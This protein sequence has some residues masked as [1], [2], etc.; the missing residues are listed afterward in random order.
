M[1]IQVTA[2]CKARHKGANTFNASFSKY[3]WGAVTCGQF[4]SAG[5]ELL[6]VEDGDGTITLTIG[7]GSI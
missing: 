6:G 4:Q 1:I 7:W 3:C 5:G 2:D